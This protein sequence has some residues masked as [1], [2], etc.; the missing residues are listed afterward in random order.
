MNNICATRQVY[1]ILQKSNE[2]IET[3]EKETSDFFIHPK[4]KALQDAVTWKLM[5]I[6]ECAADIKRKYPEICVKYPDFPVK[7]M[8]GMGKYLKNCKHYL[9]YYL[10][11]ETVQS[12]FD[13]MI[14]MCKDIICDLR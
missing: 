2:I 4:S 12:K 6:S 10:I 3:L 13:D 5:F 8:I 1:A 7:S 11:W 14:D 9:D